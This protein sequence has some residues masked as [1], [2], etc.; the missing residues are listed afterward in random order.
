MIR[1]PPRSTL[2]PYTTL[3]RSTSALACGADGESARAGHGECSDGLQLFRDDELQ[4]LVLSSKRQ[5][6]HLVGF[7]FEEAS[8]LLAQA[9]QVGWFGRPSLLGQLFHKVSQISRKL[10]VHFYPPVT[11]PSAHHYS[12]SAA[13]HCD[14]FAANAAKRHLE[15]KKRSTYTEESAREDHALCSR[16]GQRWPSRRSDLTRFHRRPPPARRGRPARSEEH[17]S[18]LQSPPQPL[19]RPFFF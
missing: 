11:T 12:Q 7:G 9:C 3:F 1:R 14:D 13:G 5:N 17:T 10:F 19:C 4:K 8:Y 15:N 6:S 2:F 18:E 16:M